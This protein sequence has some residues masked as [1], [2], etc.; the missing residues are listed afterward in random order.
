M[1]MKGYHL[2]KFR[3]GWENEHF[4]KFI[5]S[6]FSFVSEPATNQDDI[7]Y[8]LLCTF[9]NVVKFDNEE[10]KYMFP[11]N[12]FLIQIKSNEEKTINITRKGEYFDELEIPYYIGIVNRKDHLLKIFSGGTLQ[13]FFTKFGNPTRSNDPD[14]KTTLIKLI[15]DKDNG[16]YFNFEKERYYIYSFNIINIPLDYDYINDPHYINIFKS[17]SLNVQKNI[18]LRKIKEY[19]LYSEDGTQLIPYIGPGTVQRQRNKLLQ[20][21]FESA[22]NLSYIYDNIQ[23]QLSK[24]Q[25][26]NIVATCNSYQLI[27]NEFMKIYGSNSS[28]FLNLANKSLTTLKNKLNENILDS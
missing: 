13:H 24:D 10:D 12:S 9:F 3:K 20:K 15:D 14:A 5:L 23:N 7:G 19:T 28:E 1:K 26:N 22:L 16:I 17:H 6:K 21:V 25:F 11:L 27:C 2:Y 18:S 4:A 8:D